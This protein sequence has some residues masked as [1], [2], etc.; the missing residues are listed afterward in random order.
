MINQKTVFMINKIVKS[1]VILIAVNF[2][3]FSCTKD[4]DFDQADNIEITPTVESSLIFFDEPAPTFVVDDTELGTIQDSLLINFF[5]DKFIVANL[6]KSEFVFETTNSIN[7]GF[8]VRV[9]FYNNTNQLLHAFSFFA[10]PSTD[11]SNL[12]FTHI[13]VFEGNTLVALKNTAKLVF[14][15]SVSAGTPIDQ[16]TLGRIKLK[17]KAIFYLNIDD[18]I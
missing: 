14:T 9:D 6:I 3:F 12:K 18:T 16:T 15:L 1:T 7:R 10:L 5:R 8:Q 2:V 17:S 4:L 13:E 11:N